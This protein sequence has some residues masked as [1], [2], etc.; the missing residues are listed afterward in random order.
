MGARDAGKVGKLGR[1]GLCRA[2]ETL[3]DMS[4]FNLGAKEIQKNGVSGWHWQ[5]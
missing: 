1:A 3:G 5:I 2:L 4:Y